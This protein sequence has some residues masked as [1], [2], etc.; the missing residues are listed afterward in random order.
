[1][2]RKPSSLEERC[3]CCLFFAPT[4]PS[5]FLLNSGLLF[6]AVVLTAAAPASTLGPTTEDD[7]VEAGVAVFFGDSLRGLLF[8]GGGVEVGTTEVFSSVSSSLGLTLDVL[9]LLAGEDA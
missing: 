6:S 7:D 2:L 1:M 4:P 3:C 8:A 9:L 5:A